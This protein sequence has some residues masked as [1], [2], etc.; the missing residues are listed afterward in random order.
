MTSFSFIVSIDDKGLLIELKF[1]CNY[2]VCCGYYTLFNWRDLFNNYEGNSKNTPLRSVHFYNIMTTPK[3]DLISAKNLICSIFTSSI[4]LPTI[5]KPIGD[6]KLFS[7]ILYS[8][9]NLFSPF[10]SCG[11]WTSFWVNFIKV[12]M[13]N[14]FTDFFSGLL[15]P[16][17]YTI[18][19][20]SVWDN[21]L[22]ISS[23]KISKFY[24]FLWFS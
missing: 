22:K 16:N 1:F 8:L 4:P 19:E 3:G 15:T 2:D 6:R 23:L 11:L 9:L 13:Y 5:M 24:K 18:V 12:Q 20:S 21:R 7:N 17:K 10:I 14:F